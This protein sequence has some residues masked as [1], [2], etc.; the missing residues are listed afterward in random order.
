MFTLGQLHLPP[1]TRTNLVHILTLESHDAATNSH[2]FV[3]FAVFVLHSSKFVKIVSSLEKF[4]FEICTGRKC[5]P[6]RKEYRP[7]SKVCLVEIC[8]PPAS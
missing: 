5:L 2:D 3:K 6:E 7:S 8:I 1:Y 4:S